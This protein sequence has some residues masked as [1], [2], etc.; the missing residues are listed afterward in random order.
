[1]NSRM[2]SGD[3]RNAF[4][5]VVLV[6]QLKKRLCGISCRLN[7]ALGSHSRTIGSPISHPNTKTVKQADGSAAIVG[8][9]VLHQTDR[10]TGR[11]TGGV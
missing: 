6:S 9:P 10:F 7:V 8:I 1:M 4:I 11:T 3:M 5:Q 2:R